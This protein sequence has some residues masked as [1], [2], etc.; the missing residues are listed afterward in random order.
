[1]DNTEEIKKFIINDI[2]KQLKNLKYNEDYEIRNLNTVAEELSVPQI[3]P[4]KSL[5]IFIM[6]Y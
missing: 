3:K 5:I 4:K 6:H 1:M 2:S